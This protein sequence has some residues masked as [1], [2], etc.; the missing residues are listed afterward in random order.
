VTSAAYARFQ[1]FK[2]TQ[3][4]TPRLTRSTVKARGIPFAVYSS[5]P[6]GDTPPLVCINGGM[7]Y[8]HALLWPALAPLA[9]ERQLVLYDQRGRGATPPAP[10]ARTSKVEY[11]AGDVV[12][13]R[14]ALGIAR[15]DVLGHSWGGGIAMLAA[16]RDAV[17]VR[18]LVLIDAVGATSDW[19][20]AL[21][22]DAL[23]R[24]DGAAR[25]SLAALDPVTL[26]AV[27]PTIHSEYSRAIYPAYFADRDLARMFS[28]PVATSE[29]GSAVI[30]SQRRDGYDWRDI[31]RTIRASTLVLHGRD[32]VLPARL[33]QETAAL[34]PNAELALIPDAG[35][36]PFW[37]QPE[38]TF[39]AIRTF[40]ARP[41]RGR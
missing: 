2:K 30:A 37:E 13:L 15:W 12:A 39:G 18:R 11:D 31:V 9:Q 20:A 34:I 26:H 5:P 41:D 8:S 7:I 1:A 29:T 23:A 32:D 28:P 4:R 38:A 33:A 14:E 10:G 19:V 40:L 3:P 27:E 16:A 17:G 35:H 6:V 22:P 25:E 24:L 21:H 36:M